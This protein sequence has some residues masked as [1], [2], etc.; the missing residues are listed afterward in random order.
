MAFEG[1]AVWPKEWGTEGDLTARFWRGA[2][3]FWGDRSDGGKAKRWAVEGLRKD[4][5]DHGGGDQSRAGLLMIGG[6]KAGD[7]G[8]IW[9]APARR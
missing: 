2:I 1:G 4:W 3:A 7:R 6:P 8:E 5:L 9:G